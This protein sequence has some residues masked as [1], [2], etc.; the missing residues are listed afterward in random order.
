M[1]SK[2]NRRVF[3]G[4][5]A[6]GLGLL[7]VGP[8]CRAAELNRNVLIAYASRC[9]STVEIARA[10]AGD[11]KS[12]GCT[13]D[14]RAVDKVAKLTGYE[15]VVLGSA[16]RYG[17]WLPEAVEFVRTHQAELK[18]VPTAFFAVHMMNTGADEASRKARLSYLEPVHAVIRPNVEVFFAGRMDLSRLSFTERLLCKVMKGRDA[19]MRNWPA[20]HAW[21]QSVFA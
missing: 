20:I 7:A 13:V 6:A 8:R 2:L 12:R 21:A 10:V 1:T 14:L 9:G 3:L 15:A 16:V 5:S 11:L 19:D 18:R 4:A 17:H